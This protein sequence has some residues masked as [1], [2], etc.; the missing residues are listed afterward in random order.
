MEA[1]EVVEGVEEV[2]LG[3]CQPWQLSGKPDELL[4][5]HWNVPL[6]LALGVDGGDDGDDL[7]LQD[8]LV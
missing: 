7:Q 1:E 6:P 4:L 2:A 3:Q 8:G 5:W